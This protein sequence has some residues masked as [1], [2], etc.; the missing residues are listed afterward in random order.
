[1]PV[2]V[3]LCQRAVCMNAG[4]VL[5]AGAVHDVLRNHA[6]IEAYLGEAEPGDEPGTL[7][8]RE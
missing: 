1:M 7:E 3:D 2:I 6:V 4:R 8:V 5:A